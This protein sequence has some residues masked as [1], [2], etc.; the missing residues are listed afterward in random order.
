[1]RRFQDLLIGSSPQY[2]SNEARMDAAC[3]RAR[4]ALRNPADSMWGKL[5]QELREDKHELGHHRHRGYGGGEAAEDRDEGRT[6]SRT[7]TKKPNKRRY[8]PSQEQS[9]PYRRDQRP[10]GPPKST[11]RRVGGGGGRN[12]RIVHH[13]RGPAAKKMRAIQQQK[14]KE[15]E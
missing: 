9:R 1:V 8:G 4:E 14:Q 5:R 11:G 10:N 6:G 13:I 2:D 12:G 3:L 15:K 7:V